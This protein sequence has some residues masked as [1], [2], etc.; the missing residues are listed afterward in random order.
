MWVLLYSPASRT[1]IKANW[2][3]P[4]SRL[5]RVAGET[6]STSAGTAFVVFL[7]TR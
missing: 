4:S 2:E 7:D 6:F 3:L 5:L 1:S